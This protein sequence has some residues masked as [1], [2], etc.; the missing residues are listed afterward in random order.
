MHLY[1]ITGTNGKTSTSYFVHRLLDYCGIKN[2]VIGTT[3]IIANG[4]RMPFPPE[5]SGISQM[6]TPDPER[7]FGTLAEMKNDGVEYVFMEV[8]SHSLCLGRV[9]PIHFSAAAYT[10]LTPEHLDFHK[11][12]KDYFEAKASLFPKASLAIL[13]ADDAAST[14]LLP[15]CKGRVVRTSTGAHD[16]EYTAGDVHIKGVEGLDYT[17]HAPNATLKLSSRIPGLFTLSNTL[18]VAACALEMGISSRV[19]RE[20]LSSF[21]GVEGRM[22]RVKLSGCAD[23]SVFV[24]YAHTPDALENL[25]LTARSFRREGQR[26][27]LVFGCGGDRDKSKRP[28]MGSVASR[29]ADMV[30]VTSDNARSESPEAIIQ[31]ILVGIDREKPYRV[32]RDRAVAIEMAVRE[33]KAGD[34]ILLA[35]K[36]HEKYEIDGDGKHPFDEKAI[37]AAA[38]ARAYP[39]GWERRAEHRSDDI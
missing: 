15:Y 27:V 19:V 12:M 6:T 16:V 31:D 38:V 14:R 29:L 10:N 11:T 22:E 33:A 5:D 20:A 25:L 4:E 7:L 21:G 2:A 26:V 36:R 28:L 9:A 23:F 18:Q 32:I 13:N 30:Y 1:A 39:F 24:D 17:L 35:G 8:S 3:G 34:I 37:V